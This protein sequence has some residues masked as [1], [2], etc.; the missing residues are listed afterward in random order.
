M[1]VSPGGPATA[2]GPK[3]S[4]PLIPQS[5]S[6]PQGPRAQHASTRFDRDAVRGSRLR[7]VGGNIVIASWN[8]EGLTDEKQAASELYMTEYNIGVLCIQET[9]LSNS[10]YWVTENGFLILLSGSSGAVRERAGVGIIVAPSVRPAVLGFIQPSNRF[11]G[12]KLRCSGGK[13]TVIS[14]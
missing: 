6:A 13:M 10:D 7:P 8:V 4:P 1:S 14:A 3:T 2:G 5:N 11:M 9:H 12:I